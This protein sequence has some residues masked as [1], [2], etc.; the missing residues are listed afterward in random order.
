MERLEI[1][2]GARRA[3]P[4]PGAGL[5]RP[6]EFPDPDFLLFLMMSSSV[7]SRAADI[8]ECGESSTRGSEEEEESETEWNKRERLGFR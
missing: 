6:L 5:D 8:L 3:G 1:R 2:L 7:I 4:G